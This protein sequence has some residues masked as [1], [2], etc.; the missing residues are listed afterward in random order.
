MCVCVCVCVCVKVCSI[1]KRKFYE[2]KQNRLFENFLH[3][4]K[5]GI[6]WN[7]L[8][9]VHVVNSIMVVGMQ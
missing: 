1:N 6:V 8:I 5:F 4:C 7:W 3:K 9:K 2:K